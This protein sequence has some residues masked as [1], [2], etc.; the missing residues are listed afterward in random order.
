MDLHYLSNKE[1]MA[2]FKWSQLFIETIV[3][4]RMKCK[5]LDLKIEHSLLQPE[6]REKF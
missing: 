6:S 5:I 4:K 1:N 2:G 3:D